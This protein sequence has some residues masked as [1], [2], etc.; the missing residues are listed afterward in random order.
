METILQRVGDAQK[1]QYDRRHDPT[2]FR[3]GDQVM[4][5]AKNVR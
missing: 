5:A 2:R 3:I 1:K 4:L